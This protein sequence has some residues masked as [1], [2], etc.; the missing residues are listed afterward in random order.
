MTAPD[1]FAAVFTLVYML[2]AFFLAMGAAVLGRFVWEV[3]RG[4]ASS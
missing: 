1:V 4:G 2:G 3:I